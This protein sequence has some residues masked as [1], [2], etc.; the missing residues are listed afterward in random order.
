MKLPTVLF[1][2]I[3][4][5]G[6][7]AWIDASADKSGLVEENNTLVGTYNLVKL[8]RGKPIVEFTA[9]KLPK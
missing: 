8:E 9:V 3:S 7:D 2:A 1:A 6:E 4:G 5:S